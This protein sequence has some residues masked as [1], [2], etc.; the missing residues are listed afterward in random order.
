ME[1]GFIVNNIE[2]MINK[3]F[4][5]STV[6]AFDVGINFRTMRIREEMRDS[7]GFKLFIKLSQVFMPIVRLPILNG[8]RI[9]LFKAMVEIFHVTAGQFFIVQGEHKLKFCI[10]SAQEIVFDSIRESFYRI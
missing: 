1:K 6:I 7:I 2:M 5:K 4:L 3:L 8:Q 10:N 9:D